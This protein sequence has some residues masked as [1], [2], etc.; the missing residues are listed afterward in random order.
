MYP[1][2]LMNDSLV[3]SNKNFSE[4]LDILKELINTKKDELI[5]R[6]TYNENATIHRDTKQVQFDNYIETFLSKF[7]IIPQ[8]MCGGTEIIDDE[9]LVICRIDDKWVCSSL[10]QVNDFIKEL[11]SDGNNVDETL[12]DFS[13]RINEIK[14]TRDGDV[15][16]SIMQE[17]F[18]VKNKMSKEEIDRIL[19]WVKE[20]NNIHSESSS[21]I[22]PNFS[23]DKSLKDG[24]DNKE[25]ILNDI[26]SWTLKDDDFDVEMFQSFIKKLIK[27]DKHS[28]KLVLKN[29]NYKLFRD[30]LG[31]DTDKIKLIG[32]KDKDVKKNVYKMFDNINQGKKGKKSVIN[33]INELDE[34]DK[35]D[36][37]GESD[38]EREEEDL[39]YD[40]DIGD[41]GGDE[42]E[43]IFDE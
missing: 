18:K 34:E 8:K 36:N 41:D 1:E 35:G 43:I 27:Y 3:N 32:L 30:I 15:S 20:G 40:M 9:H 33:E 4:F 12:K 5:T 26:Y 6:Y 39:G 31:G 21:E 28:D 19:N 24:E 7:N 14:H 38:N 25:T 42:E 16:N 17:T 10:K 29:I 23:L 37:E 11:E 2:F 13:E 22:S